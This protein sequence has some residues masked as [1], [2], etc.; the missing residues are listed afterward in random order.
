MGSGVADKTQHCRIVIRNGSDWVCG[1]GEAHPNFIRNFA[2][3]SGGHVAHEFWGGG[4][5]VAEF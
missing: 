5:G 4:C 3:T 2:A 1:G